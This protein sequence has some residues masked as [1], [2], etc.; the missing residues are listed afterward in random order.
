MSKE[1]QTCATP[2]EKIRSGGKGAGL[3]VGGGKGPM[4]VPR[5]GWS[6]EQIKKLLA[7]LKS[8]KLKLSK[9]ASDTGE[10]K[11]PKPAALKVGMPLS[12]VK[13]RTQETLSG[14]INRRG[15]GAGGG[16]MPSASAVPG[17]GGT[18]SYLIAHKTRALT[19]RMGFA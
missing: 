13:T 15:M 19:P 3:A 5:E 1:R 10:V 2:G 14:A 11:L 17:A 9:V 18:K 16:G 4:G 12:G 8:G 6:S 7:A